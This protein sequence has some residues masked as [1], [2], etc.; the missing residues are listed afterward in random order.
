MSV[1]NLVVFEK[2]SSQHTTFF[3]RFL[4]WF[5]PFLFFF[6]PPQILYVDALD[7]PSLKIPDIT[8]RVAAWSRKLLDELIKLDTNND[9][10]FGK[11]KV[12]SSNANIIFLPVFLF[13]Q[14]HTNLS[15]FVLPPF[16]LKQLPNTTVHKSLFRPEDI[17]QF[18]ASKV[19][20][21]MP[22]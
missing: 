5:S 18:V 21:A 2:P 9:G 8:P 14:Q 4:L 13:C 3:H 17:L 20:E 11:L 1:S 12:W 19:P 6:L 7:A 10:S 15:F 16:Q 22:A